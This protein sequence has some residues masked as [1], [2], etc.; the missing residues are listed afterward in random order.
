MPKYNILI[1]Y[2][3][4]TTLGFVPD[5]KVAFVTSAPFEKE[6][7]KGARRQCSILGIAEIDI[8][9]INIEEIAP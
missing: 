3:R 5:Q 8:A 2:F 9:G 6:A 4:T 1:R 7:M